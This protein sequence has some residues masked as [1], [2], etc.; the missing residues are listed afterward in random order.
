[1]DPEI[2]YRIPQILRYM[3]NKR[4]ILN[5]I[6]PIIESNIDEKKMFFDVFAGTNSVGYAIKTTNGGNI[7][8]VTNDVQAYSYVI[9]KALIE[10]NAIHKIPLYEAQSD[11]MNNFKNNMNDISKTWSD[12]FIK[13]HQ[14]RTHLSDK[15]ISF[16]QFIKKSIT[17]TPFCLFSFYFTNVYFSL[18]QCKEIDSL[19][20]AIEQIKN[21]IKKNIY[22]ICLLY[23]VSYGSSTFGHFAQP[24]KV[25]EE[26]LK[27]REKSISEL[28][29]KK[30]SELSIKKNN[31]KNFCFNEDYKTLFTRKEFKKL[32]NKIGF[33]YVDPPYSTANYSRFYHILETLVKY[34]Y[35]ENDYKGLY[36][37]DRFKSNFCKSRKVEEEFRAVFEFVKDIEA[38]MVVSYINSGLGLLPKERLVTLCEEYFGSKNVTTFPDIPHIHSTLGNRTKKHVKEVLILCRP[39]HHAV[40]CPRRIALPIQTCRHGIS[41]LALSAG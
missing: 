41:Q 31:K 37:E 29:F 4:S 40:R 27:I 19:R 3:G 15:E 16:Q 6:I 21:P 22:L 2:N 14:Y 33:V 7:G 1:M 8:V 30:L 36:R 24:R 18:E 32:K 11:L 38:G 23:A 5:R 39:A 12:A 20:F 34:D 25:T 17:E 9:S 13:N 28:F 35:P 26:V 10:N